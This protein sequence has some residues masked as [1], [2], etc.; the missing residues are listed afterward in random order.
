MATVPFAER[1]THINPQADGR[2]TTRASDA[3]IGAGLQA[4]GEGISR[5][6]GTAANIMARREDA[7]K[8][9]IGQ[10]RLMGAMGPVLKNAGLRMNAFM[11]LQGAQANSVEEK[12]LAADLEKL[13]AEGGKD[14]TG[15][16]RELFDQRI[17]DHIRAW[18]VDANRHVL[19]QQR[20]AAEEARKATQAGALGR[21]AASGGAGAAS[22]ADLSLARATAYD[23][24]DGPEVQ[25]QKMR[26]VTGRAV[27]G[28]VDASLRREVPDV[29]SARTVFEAKKDLIPQELVPKVE[30][31]IRKAEVEKS[32][33]D[34]ADGVVKQV[35]A[36]LPLDL[37]NP[38]PARL[39]AQE[40]EAEKRIQ[41][42]PALSRERKD[43]RVRRVKAVIGDARSA[44][45]R[46]RQ[47]DEAVW[48]PKVLG[49][50]S[51]TTATARVRTAPVY[52]QKDLQA[53][54]DKRAAKEAGQPD[55]ITDPNQIRHRESIFMRLLTL[56]VD[57][58]KNGVG[59]YRNKDALI[60]N[61]D[62]A[63]MPEESKE[64]L[65]KVYEGKGEIVPG[66]TVNRVEEAIKGVIGNRA[67]DM[68][69]DDVHAI[70]LN[71]SSAWSP[72]KNYDPLTLQKAV[73]AQFLKV[74]TTEKG[75]MR[76][77][78]AIKAGVENTIEAIEDKE[79]LSEEKAAITARGGNPDP[80][81]ELTPD[82]EEMKSVLSWRLGLIPGRRLIEDQQIQ[83][84]SYGDQLK[85]IIDEEQERKAKFL[86]TEEKRARDILAGTA[87][88]VEEPR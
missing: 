59:V 66:L 54:V 30:E 67:K 75:T 85:K 78:E 40:L 18:A 39:S 82:T 4:L 1:R 72:D 88:L 53:L 25:E 38:D 29:I 3:N 10:A 62:L 69:A 45:I 56:R 55:V 41:A 48:V 8:K 50:A 87:D 77:Y 17:G 81:G 2:D 42:D 84:K 44:L 46:R 71:V 23:P 9:K 5:A 28:A 51:T 19:G 73:A 70:Y 49:E 64:R 11:A 14:L 31:A 68:S 43:L 12:K 13:R 16:E 65:L 6:G 79:A 24:T 60:L 7:E 52:L 58:N 33:T 61:M 37:E 32:D 35:Q 15:E 27:L 74:R 83:A 21:Y 47:E 57:D 86:R 80:L 76:A 20:I 36:D 63:R 34:F 26:D 22:E